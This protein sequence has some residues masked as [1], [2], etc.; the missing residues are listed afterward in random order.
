MA[1]SEA[2]V[3]VLTYFHSITGHLSLRGLRLSDFLNDRRESVIRLSNVSVSRLSSPAKVITRDDLAVL[4]KD[5]VV[6][7]FETTQPAVTTEKRTYAFTLKQAHDVFLIME[8]VEVHGIIHMKGSFDALEIHRF[9]ATS[10][11][12]FVPVTEATV[13]LPDLNFSKQTGVMVNVHHIHYIAK[14]K[15]AA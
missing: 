4:N 8:S 13:T 1:I 15:P 5:H 2:N 7:V 3:V 6:M 12:A 9:I 11:E 14:T 10:G